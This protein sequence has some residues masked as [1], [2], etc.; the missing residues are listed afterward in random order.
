MA[1]VTDNYVYNYGKRKD[2]AKEHVITAE[3]LK[4]VK[5]AARKYLSVKK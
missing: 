2:G 5:E 1:T 4:Q 3:Q